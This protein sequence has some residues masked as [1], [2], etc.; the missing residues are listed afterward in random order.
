LEQIL[1]KYHWARQYRYLFFYLPGFLFLFSAFTTGNKAEGTGSLVLV[2]EPIFD[3]VP[4]KL[5]TSSYVDAHGDTLYIDAFRFYISNLQWKNG[6][7]Y[8]GSEN[9]HLVDAEN[10]SSQTI[11]FENVF[12]GTYSGIRFLLGVDSLANVSGAM[13]GD[14]DPVKGMYWAWNSGYVNAK[15]TG[16]SGACKTLHSAFEF[17]IG[18][19][20]PPNK[21]ERTVVLNVDSLKI[22]PGNT[23]VLR[24]KADGLKAR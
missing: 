1:K 8:Y 6:E 24:L 17:H 10:V 3:S 5:N 18:G 9:C 11:K 23:T 13:S 22:K 12:P 21:T 4:L 7:N 16:R 15:L 20:L 14:L 19:Y 2:I